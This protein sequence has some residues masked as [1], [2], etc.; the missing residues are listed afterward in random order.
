MLVITRLNTYNMSYRIR[1][2]YPCMLFCALVICGGASAQWNQRYA[3]ISQPN[4]L[5]AYMQFG[6][7][8]GSAHISNI[9]STVL[10]ANVVLTVDYV[11]QKSRASG[12]PADYQPGLTFMFSDGMPKQMLKGICI[13]GARSISVAGESFRFLG[14]GGVFI[15]SFA[16]PVNFRKKSQGWFEENYEMDWKTNKAIGLV[17]HPAIEWP[18]AVPFGLTVGTRVTITSVK[19]T[20]TIEFNFLVGRVRSSRHQRG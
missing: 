8:W 15:G 17:L 3:Y 6:G 13:E 9:G 11:E 16:Y 18:C 2:K 20:A 19:T 1:K 10:Y 12:I 4:Q 7:G 14:R 5:Y